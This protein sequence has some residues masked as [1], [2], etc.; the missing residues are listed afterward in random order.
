[1]SSRSFIGF[2]LA[3]R[4]LMLVR[5]C[6]SM[7][8][9][10]GVFPETGWAFETSVASPKKKAAKKGKRQVMTPTT[11]HSEYMRGALLSERDR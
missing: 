11:R 4:L 10:R 3:A 8:F 6:G 1:M 7:F 2:R 9:P 5:G